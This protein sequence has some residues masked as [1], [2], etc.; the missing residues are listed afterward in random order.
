[1]RYSGGYVDNGCSFRSNWQESGDEVEVTF[2]IDFVP[3]KPIFDININDLINIRKIPSICA[4][5]INRSNRVLYFIEG[6]NQQ[7]LIHDVGNIG[8]EF[9][10]WEF[11]VK[12][13]L[14]VDKSLLS[15]TKDT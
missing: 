11:L 6:T 5:N 2:D 12:F 1:M 15:S 8:E 13:C 9:G 4:K 7:L 10:I 14:L 3:S